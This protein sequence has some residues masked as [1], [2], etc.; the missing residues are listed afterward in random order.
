MLINR[1]LIFNGL[2]WVI[3]PE[4]DNVLIGMWRYTINILYTAILS[5]HN[6]AIESDNLGLTDMELTKIYKYYSQWDVDRIQTEILDR[7]K[8]KEIRNLFINT[9]N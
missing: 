1:F 4:R 5:W 2:N 3:N 9:N 8:V 6:S 7:S